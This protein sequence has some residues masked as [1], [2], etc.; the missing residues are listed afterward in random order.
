VEWDTGFGEGGIK[1]KAWVK[2]ENTYQRLKSTSLLCTFM[3]YLMNNYED[4][5]H[6]QYYIHVLLTD[7]IRTYI[8]YYSSR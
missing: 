3:L 8:L 2:R 5:D 4:F 6:M 1:N 7:I